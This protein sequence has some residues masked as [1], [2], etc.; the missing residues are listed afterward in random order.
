MSNIYFFN[1]CLKIKN[2]IFYLNMSQS[3]DTFYNQ[4]LDEEA[5]ARAAVDN[6]K[7]EK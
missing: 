3:F 1:E 4:I 6:A 2:I 5:K 7:K